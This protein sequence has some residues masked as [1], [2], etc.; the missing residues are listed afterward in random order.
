MFVLGTQN[1]EAQRSLSFSPFWFPLPSIEPK[2]AEVPLFSSGGNSLLDEN[3]D[4]SY[5]VS[6]ITMKNGN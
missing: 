6:G 1:Y 5:S 2:P 4:S 3:L